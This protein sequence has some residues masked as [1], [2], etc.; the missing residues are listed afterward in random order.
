[1]SVFHLDNKV[2]NQF[3]LHKLPVAGKFYHDDLK[4][5]YAVEFLEQLLDLKS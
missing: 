1:M 3:D 5:K 4:R 2:R